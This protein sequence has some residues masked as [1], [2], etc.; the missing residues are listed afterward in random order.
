MNKTLEHTT[1]QPLVEQAV[2]SAKSRYQRLDTPQVVVSPYRFNPMGAHIDHQGGEVMART[3]DQYTVLAFYPAERNVITLR[4]SLAEQENSECVFT[5]GDRDASANWV[6]YAQASMLC[7]SSHAPV[8]NGISGV[9]LGTLVSAGLSSSASV[10][11]AYLSALAFVNDI[12]LSSAELVELCRQV[13]NEHMGLNNGIQDQM[14]VAFGQVDALSILDVNTSSAR[15]IPNHASTTDVSWVLCYSGFS[16]ELVSSGFNDR[17][18]EC[19][20][21][22]ALLDGSVQRLGDVPLDKR[23]QSQLDELPAHLARRAKHVYSEMARVQE[24]AQAWEQGLWQVF[25]DLMN[26]SCKSS[27]EDYECGSE[28]MVV[29]HRLAQSHQHVFGSRF[30]GGGYGGCLLMLVPAPQALLVCKEI[31]AGFVAEYPEKEGI[32]KAFIAHPEASVRVLENI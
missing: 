11:L 26:A 27:I 25:G 13:E 16:R 20:E 7:L 23:M 28:P 32:A 24:G 14:S 31:L 6:R 1:L 8:V 9:V 12:T 10:I 5:V 29:L 30:S 19:K 15:Y 18:R 2:E 4:H 21:A 22:A 3:I 17:V